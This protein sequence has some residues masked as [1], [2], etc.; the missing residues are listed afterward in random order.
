MGMVTEVTRLTPAELSELQPQT[1]AAGITPVTAKAS[2]L[3]SRLLRHAEIA[4]STFTSLFTVPFKAVSVRLALWL[5]KPSTI[6][7][8]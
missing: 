8:P 6:A 3:R 4:V 2:A 7:Q 1:R 5:L